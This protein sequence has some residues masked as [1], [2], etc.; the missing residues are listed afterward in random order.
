MLDL[1]RPMRRSQAGREEQQP[2]NLPVGLFFLLLISVYTR[3]DPDVFQCD[4]TGLSKS[5][6]RVTDFNLV[7]AIVRLGWAVVMAMV[8]SSC[9]AFHRH[10][11][12]CQQG[13]QHVHFVK[14]LLIKLLCHVR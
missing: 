13:L 12:R 7:K 4:K 5:A 1:Q 2:C 10:F 6:A 8:S 11:S 9:F 14:L 3:S